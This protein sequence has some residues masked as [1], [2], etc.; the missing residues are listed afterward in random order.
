MKKSANIAI[1]G[2]GIMG[3]CAAAELVRRGH[4]N[5][6][7]FDPAGFPADNASLMAGGMLA[8]YAEI[9]HMSPAWIKAG[10]RGIEFW[11]KLAKEHDL[12]FSRQGS[13]LIAHQQDAYILERFKSHLPSGLE[14]LALSLNDIKNL[15]PALDERFSHGLHLQD[16]AH[17]DPHKTVAALLKILAAADV[18]FVQQA[19]TPSEMHGAYD[20]IIDCR[21]M[22]AQGNDPDLRGVKGE[23][24]I[25]QNPDFHLN[26]PLRL[27]H[28]RYPLYIVPRENH[29]FMI[30]ATMVESSGNTDVSVRSALELLSALYSLHPSFGD[31][32]IIKT[33]AGIRPSYADNLP[34]VRMDK[35]VISCNGL[36]RHGYLLAPLMADCVADHLEGAENEYMSLLKGESQPHEDHAEW[37]EKRTAAGL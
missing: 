8:P 18:R 24:V 21:G 10:L 22:G 32:Q 17:L 30:G 13:L 15:E 11:Q 6:T 4:K 5:L 37:P 7:L 36:F 25:A 34:R 33:I 3:L 20:H 26:R 16:E 31:A 2:A 28:P 35:N 29:L 12:D 23:I 9:E 1:L 27:M 19:K 14:N